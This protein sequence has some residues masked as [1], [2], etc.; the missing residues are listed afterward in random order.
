MDGY[1][2][3][4]KIN[5]DIIDT[6]IEGA[7]TVVCGCEDLHLSPTPTRGCRSHQQF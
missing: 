2:S 3:Q 7:I 1:I 5:S 4:R 6:K